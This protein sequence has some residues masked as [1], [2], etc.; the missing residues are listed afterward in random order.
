MKLYIILHDTMPLTQQLLDLAESKE[1][2]VFRQISYC[3]TFAALSSMF[4]GRLLCD[5]Q[6]N[7]IGWDTRSKYINKNNKRIEFS[8]GIIFYS[9]II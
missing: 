8:L 3:Y 5:L 4:T 6:N 1:L 7:G 2:D 9:R